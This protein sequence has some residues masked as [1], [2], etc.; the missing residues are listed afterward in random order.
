MQK[1]E[2]F[3]ESDIFF[4]N[5]DSKPFF[6]TIFAHN[7]KNCVNHALVYAIYTL[8]IYGFITTEIQ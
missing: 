2:S 1:T 7:L 6:F 8:N 4:K 3:K 5:S